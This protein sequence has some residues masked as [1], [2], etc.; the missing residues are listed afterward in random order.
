MKVVLACGGTGGH[1][2]PGM[3]IAESFRKLK[4]GVEIVFVGTPRG[5]EGEILPKAGWRLEKIPMPSLADKKGLKKITALWEVLGAL[6]K[7]RHFLK[8]ERPGLVLGVGGYASGPVLLAASWMKIPTVIVE[9]NAVPGL[10]NRIL[11]Y[12]VDHIFICA[13]ELESF[14]GKKKTTTISTP[15]R[16]SILQAGLQTARREKQNG[17]T[18]IFVFG[19]S[20][21]ARKINA[22]LLDALPYLTPLKEKIYFIHQVGKNENSLLI[23]EDYKQKGFSAEVHPF[24]QEMESFY[25][26]SDFVIARAGANTVAELKA[27]HLPSLLIPYPHSAGGHQEANARALE[28]LGGAKVLLENEATGEALAGVIQQMVTTPTLM[29][30]M[31]K[32]LFSFGKEN[33]A[34]A[35]VQWCHKTYV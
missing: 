7:A 28:K 21:G 26:R 11:K 8:Q 18:V 15:V 10:A 20:L 35:I 12:F 2:F 34:D 31:Q 32:K 1:I 6:K 27:L 9:I 16:E 29:K 19:G 22:A 14:F 4:K 23:R 17:K 30:E 13:P 24:I 33:G 5:L 25:R 3:A